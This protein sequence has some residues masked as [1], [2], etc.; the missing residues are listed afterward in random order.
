MLAFL[1]QAETRSKS[2]LPTPPEKTAWQQ[3]Q[4]C[5]QQQALQL[6]IQQVQQRQQHAQELQMQRYLEAQK[7]YGDA[8]HRA[9]FEAFHAGVSIYV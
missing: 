2:G 5:A 3:H 6:Q 9:D 1:H 7:A 8:Y 4:I